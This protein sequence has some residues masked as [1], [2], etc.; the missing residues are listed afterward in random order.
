MIRRLIYALTGKCIHN[1]DEWSPIAAAVLE[2][3]K[4]HSDG[5][6]WYPVGVMFIQLRRCKCCGLQR[7]TAV[8]HLSDPRSDTFRDIQPN[9][10]GPL[11][12]NKTKVG[13]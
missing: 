10:I 5:T 11:E 9:R 7:T 13:T 2:G 1:W 3:Y 8:R 4:S 12:I 6:R